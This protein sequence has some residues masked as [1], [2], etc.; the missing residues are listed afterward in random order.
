VGFITSVRDQETCV[1]YYV[2]FDYGV[3]QSCPLY[4]RLLQVCIEDALTLNCRRV[5]FGR[6]ALEPKA[7]M[8]AKP[9]A[10]SVRIRHRQP[11]VNRLIRSL[12][13]AIPHDEA[14]DRDPFKADSRQ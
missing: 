4:F 3:N 13:A 10:M 6:T 14:P 1:G 2:G 12:L 8:G 7:R 9:Q 11:L 5:S